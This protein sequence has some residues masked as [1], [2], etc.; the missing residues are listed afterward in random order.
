MRSRTLF[1]L[2]SRLG[3]VGAALIGASACGAPPTVRTAPTV[4]AAPRC[5]ARPSLQASAS[6]P[7]LVVQSGHASGI[8]ALRFASNGL[9]AS[10]S[11]DNTVRIWDSS[12]HVL[13]VLTNVLVTRLVWSADGTR[14]ALT[15]AWGSA[16]SIVEPRSGAADTRD[17]AA[18]DDAA[19][20]V[21]FGTGWLA[22]TRARLVQVEA[23]AAA[24]ATELPQSLYGLDFLE[25]SADGKTAVGGQKD[26]VVFYAAGA[27]LHRV[28]APG[29]LTALAPFPDGSAAV[30]VTEVPRSGL[31]GAQRAGILRRDGTYE[32]LDGPR[33]GVSGV[34]VSR[35][36]VIAAT[37]A[38][39]L[40]LWTSTGAPLRKVEL[41]NTTAA[42]GF[43]P[44]GRT[45][46]A[47]ARTGELHRFDTDSGRFLGD[48]GDR[49]AVSAMG[50]AF[51]DDEHLV[52]ASR[53][54]LTEWDLASMEM[55]AQVDAPAVRGA[56]RLPDGSMVALFSGSDYQG[57]C[58]GATIG[59]WGWS[60]RLPDMPS[61]HN[62]A[63]SSGRRARAVTVDAPPIAMPWLDRVR[64][65]PRTCKTLDEYGDFDDHALGH[66][67]AFAWT[68]GG[69]TQP[70]D[71]AEDPGAAPLPAFALPAAGIVVR[72]AKL[73]AGGTAVVGLMEGP[74]GSAGVVFD[75]AGKAIGELAF[76]SDM[77]PAAWVTAIAP[78]GSV[79]AVSA[80]DSLSQSTP[81]KPGSSI[82]RLG[83]PITSLEYASSTD[84]LVGTERGDLVHVVDGA[85]ATRAQGDGSSI[86]VIRLSPDGRRIA[87]V[88]ED[89][90]VELWQS[91]DLSR[92]RLLSFDDQEW[93][94]IATS[95]WYAASPGGRR[96]VGWIFGEQTVDAPSPSA[97]DAAPTGQFATFE[98]FDGLLGSPKHIRDLAAGRVVPEPSMARP[99]TLELV[100]APP[101]STTES[102][103]SLRAAF[104][105]SAPVAEVRGFVEGKLV[106]TASVCAESGEVLLDMPLLPGAN[107][108]SVMAF[109]A[110]GSAS[111]PATAV[112]ERAAAKG[113]GKLHVVAIGVGRYPRLPRSSQLEF[114]DDDAFMIASAFSRQA[115]DATLYGEVVATIVTDREALL[116]PTDLRAALAKLDAVGP[117]D[118]AILSL[119]G[120]GVVVGEGRGQEL[121]LLGSLAGEDDASILENSLAW[122]DIESALQR[123]KGRVLVLVDACHAGHLA[124]NLV[125]PSGELVAKL[126]DSDR[127]GA[128]VFAAARGREE[129]FERDFS[130]VFTGA[131]T[132]A[133]PM[134]ATDRDANGF[135]ELS[136][137]VD[138]VRRD[139][140]QTTEGLQTPWLARSE[141]VGDFAI[142]PA[143][144]AVSV[145]LT[146]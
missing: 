107:H 68:S 140:V 78:D 34:A 74:G 40:W 45:L 121:R 32:P 1:A 66:L 104:R 58:K 54:R 98:Q 122:A 108:L 125:A 23:H 105:G 5:D 28:T 95:G 103:L 101:A 130:G 82:L 116:G 92:V 94:A 18:L 35:E 52:V 134:R 77:G 62:G 11:E 46:V 76:A 127:A 72:K 138:V 51:A 136:E 43:S 131:I 143:G 85:V 39:G 133:L 4:E 114:A 3:L 117:D 53:G 60:G 86:T 15:T 123:A 145:Q 20:L 10:S 2:G 8:R 146:P 44:D 63:R 17:A 48:I 112:V 141:L 139:V 119:S 96:H 106:A 135:I 93:L 64:A 81:G 97:P 69:G 37:G 19:L 124:P 12:G 29:R 144:S 16:T 126:A 128:I 99:P 79:F 100:L 89:G 80:G 75:P 70:I 30:V 65:H 113:G 84:L 7:R 83:D 67:R 87:T 109:G 22:E 137:L 59:L 49:P 14:L 142:V 71:L 61:A 33:Y 50:V 13:N 41:E 24:S 27:A 129:S 31:G 9:L 102:S 118:T 57:P 36:G 21:P 115:A 88:G 73:A 56:A 26:V 6:R 42:L 91:A 38:D 132:R 111:L 120:H 25:L 55:T 110:D 90:R 47:G